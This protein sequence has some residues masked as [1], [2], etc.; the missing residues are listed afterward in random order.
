MVTTTK[1]VA[2][3]GD[4]TRASW[5]FYLDCVERKEWLY[6]VHDMDWIDCVGRCRD[7]LSGVCRGVRR[8]GF[9]D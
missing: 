8:D 1:V 3:V 4:R 9:D 6:E 5:F 2:S 7:D